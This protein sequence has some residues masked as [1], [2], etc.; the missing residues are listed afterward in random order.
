MAGAAYLQPLETKEVSCIGI[1]ASFLVIHLNTRRERQLPGK[2]IKMKWAVC[3]KDILAIFAFGQIK[4]V[5]HFIRELKTLQA[6]F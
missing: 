2:D 3:M 6:R 1:W 5:I 4:A